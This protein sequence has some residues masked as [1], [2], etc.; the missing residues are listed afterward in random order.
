MTA[1]NAL[2]MKNVQKIHFQQNEYKQI[3]KTEWHMAQARQ[4]ASIKYITIRMD[5][6]YKQLH[7][8]HL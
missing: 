1:L 5:Q 8:G 4:C 2:E 6:S 7:A 3:V